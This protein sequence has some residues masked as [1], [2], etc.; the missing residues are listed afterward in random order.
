MQR[1]RAVLAPD[2]QELLENQV[3]YFFFVFILSWSMTQF[4]LGAGIVGHLKKKSLNGLL[5]LIC[6]PFRDGGMTIRLVIKYL[7]NKL[8]LD[9]ESE[10]C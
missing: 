5:L 9:D 3:M 6:F 4:M 8:K 7:V 2:I 10:V 1:K